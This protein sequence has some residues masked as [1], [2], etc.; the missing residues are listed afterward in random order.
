MGIRC[1][2]ANR[3]KALWSSTWDFHQCLT[4]FDN[5]SDFGTKSKT[6]LT[7][8]WWYMGPVQLQRRISRH[9]ETACAWY[10]TYTWIEEPHCIQIDTSRVHLHSPKNIVPLCPSCTLHCS[11]GKVGYLFFR[12]CACLSAWDERHPH[13]YED[14]CSSVRCRLER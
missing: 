5:G 14:W 1:N 2:T 10:E 7:I 9:A 3:S 11:K 8:G 12:V 4:R 6:E 13:T